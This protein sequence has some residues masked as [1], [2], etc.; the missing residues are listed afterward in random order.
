MTLAGAGTLE[1]RGTSAR[2]LREARL[3]LGADA[4]FAATLIGRGTN[5]L[6]R[7]TWERPGVGNVERIVVRSVDGEAVRGTGTLT[8]AEGA[9]TMPRRLALQWTARDGAHRLEL[10]VPG[11]DDDPPGSW[12]AGSGTRVVANIDA[13]AKGDGLARMQG[14]RGGDFAVVRARIGTGGDVV[15]DVDQP[16]RG[17]IRGRVRR[18]Q[19]RR[20][21]VA[22]TT[23]FGYTASGTLTIRLRSAEE[24]QRWQGSG[25]G[26]RGP[27]SLDFEGSGV[28]NEI[29]LPAGGATASALL[30]DRAE[31]GR[32]ALIRGESLGLEVGMATV[33]L[34]RGRAATL[35][36]EARRE[37]ITLEGRWLEAEGGLVQFEIR[38]INTRNASGRLTLRR[39]G[40]S[41]AW[42]EG[43]GRVDGQPF[44]LTFVVR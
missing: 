16:T 31:R 14:V 10:S 32:G 2:E 29:P 27:W 17:E 18:V 15:L 9:R 43:D 25:S 3:T 42:I 40:A 8:Y 13:R 37:R 21:E 41:F 5:M 30:M 35:V 36:L 34:E 19:G 11:A 28:P 24:V 4:G 12:S 44:A 6:V 38:R 26:E 33:R 23:V 1:T 20:V 39:E 22:I 7:G